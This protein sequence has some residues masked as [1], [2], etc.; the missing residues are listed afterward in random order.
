[1]D[2]YA[3]AK[4]RIFGPTDKACAQVR[5]PQRPRDDGHGAQ[6]ASPL[7]TSASAPICPSGRQLRRA[8]TRAACPGWLLAEPDTEADADEA[9]PPQGRAGRRG[10]RC[11]V[12]REAP[13][14]GRRAAHPRHAQRHQRAGRAG[15]VPRHRPA[16]ERRCCTACASIA[17]SRTASNWWPRSTSVEYYDDSKGT[18]VGATVAAL[19]AWAGASPASAPGADR[20]RR[21]QGPGFD[22]LAD[23]GRRVR[24]RGAADRPRRAGP[25]TPRW[26]HGGVTCMRASTWPTAGRRSR[27]RPPWRKPGDAVLLSPA[28]ASLDMFTQLRA[29]RAGVHRHRARDRARRRAGD[30]DRPSSCHSA[31]RRR[32]STEAIDKPRAAVEDAME[33]DQPLVLVGV[34]IL[35]LLRPGDGVFGLDRAAGLAQVTPPTRTITS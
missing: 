32:S 1:M 26:Q 29:P 17:A 22:P 8:A 12:R 15:A 28:C 14:A 7:R 13:D 6:P 10:S 2:A 9:A 19:M 18:N 20:R 31:S 16:V 21:R 33:Y 27:A 4:A 34:L 11:R 30:S 25:A 3:A 24:A 5:E 23:A 35:M